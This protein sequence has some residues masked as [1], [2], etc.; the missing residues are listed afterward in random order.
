MPVPI[1]VM[2]KPASGAC[3]LQCRYCFYSAL[4]PYRDTF[5]KGFM[6]PQTA[7]RVI[8]AALAF[9]GDSDV[10]F[11]FQGGEPL[12]RG[13]EFY[14]DFTSYAKC[15]NN[16][17]AKIVYCL[18][19]NGTLLNAQWCRFF[20]KNDFLVGV[21]LDGTR[22]QNADRVYP[23]GRESFDD[24]LRG[25]ECLRQFDVAFNILAVLTRKTARSV[26]ESY[27]YFKESGF[28]YFQYITGLA[29]FGSSRSENSLFMEPADYAYFLDK[30][31]RLYYNDL[32]RGNAV[33]VRQFDNF[34]HLA[35]GH[36]AEQCGM[37][38][39][40]S[41]QFVVESD[42]SVYPC[43]FYCTDDWLLGNIQTASFQKLAESQ[44]ARAFLNASRTL[45]SR[46][47]GC[48][49]LAVCRGCGCR[50]VRDDVDYC[51][52]YRS[53]FEAHGAQLQQLAQIF[54]RHS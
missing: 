16:G 35:A 52:A 47:N 14:Q 3:N 38:G 28:R 1:S 43:D 54:F 19:T 36:Y 33:S 31:F 20:K 50:R 18:Q 25:I 30:A 41:R 21:S 5:F 45:P 44:K 51:S 11:T 46:C 17:R 8:D 6:Q 15:A 34:V 42:G 23:D 26:R 10:F 49:Y 12:L 37:N 39:F 29:P 27:R 32:T 22:Q 2:L 40:C 48:A 9:A 13:L 24:V 4:Q 7:H 53:F